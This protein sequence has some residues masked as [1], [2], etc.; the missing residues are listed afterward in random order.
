MKY[1]SASRNTKRGG[2]MDKK[3]T[4]GIQGNNHT[5]EQ[6][7]ENNA[8][9]SLNSHHG[10]TQKNEFQSTWPNHSRCLVLLLRKRGLF[11]KMIL[12]CPCAYFHMSQRPHCTTLFGLMHICKAPILIHLHCDKFHK[13]S[14]VLL[15]TITVEKKISPINAIP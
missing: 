8:Y 5:H 6:P 14:C 1:H 11:C 12:S 4:S 13:K 2:A 10:R 9:S 15:F 7:K 3:E